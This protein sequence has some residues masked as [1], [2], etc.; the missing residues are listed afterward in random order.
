MFN[1]TT[2]GS[3]TTIRV[4]VIKWWAP[5]CKGTETN[6]NEETKS[7]RIKMSRTQHIKYFIFYFSK[8]LNQYL[9]QIHILFYLNAILISNN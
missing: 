7:L 9:L 2:F 8:L 3:S 4:R 5:N 6:K 1:H